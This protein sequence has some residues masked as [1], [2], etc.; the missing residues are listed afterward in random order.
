ML[1]RFIRG[2]RKAILTAFKWSSLVFTT[3]VL[4]IF[5]A[6]LINNQKPDPGL[7]I[8]VVL[9]ASVGLPVFIIAVGFLRWYW[10]SYVTDR[11]FGSFPFSELASIGFNKVTINE[12]KTKFMCDYYTGNIDGFIVDCDVDTQHDTKY[13]RFK[14][15]VKIRPLGKAGYERIQDNFKT[16]NADV[17]FNWI[18]KKYHYKNHR[19]KSVKELEKELIDFAKLI[20]KEKIDQMG[21]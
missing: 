4:I 20:K 7:F 12:N 13:L 2:N 14:Y 16:Q 17:D 9:T 10:G 8:T 21:Y 19:I 5:L 15:F 18:S 6:G 3:I 11:N 1:K